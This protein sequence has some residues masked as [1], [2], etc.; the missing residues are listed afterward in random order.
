MV[1][2]C[3]FTY[4]GVGIGDNQPG[5][6]VW[7]VK[8]EQ[9]NNCLFLINENFID[10]VDSKPYEGA[11]TAK[12]RPLTFRFLEKPR[13]A[14]IPTGWSVASGGFQSLDPLTKKAI[15]TSF[16]RIACLLT[17]F[18]YDTVV[19]SADAKN[20]M[21]IGVNIFRPSEEILDYISS[22]II[23]LK[24]FDA[25]KHDV[26]ASE[27]QIDSIEN[28]LYTHAEAVRDLARAQDKI[29][30][31]EQNCVCSGKRKR[32]GFLILN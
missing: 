22:K 19:Y 26:P 1:R 14:G 7:M 20:T 31:L 17:K 24:T 10:S 29:A 27:R 28:I 30:V 2:V 18:S 5:D 15:D 21:R 11:G 25:D 9:Y 8:Q 32:K 16:K 13:A 23:N 12:L 3:G 4:K 6:F